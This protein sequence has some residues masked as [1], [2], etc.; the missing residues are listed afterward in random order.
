[1][2]WGLMMRWSCALTNWENFRHIEATTRNRLVQDWVQ[3]LLNL[4]EK[5]PEIEVLS[6]GEVQPGAVGD[7]NT[8]V[9]A[10]LLFE[11]KPLAKE[12]LRKIYYWLYEDMTARLP[13]DIGLG[14]TE[15]A[16][17]KR[18]FLVGQPVDLGNFG[19]LR[20]ALGI[21]NICFME[22]HGVERALADDAALVRKISLLAR[23]HDRIESYADIMGPD[24]RREAS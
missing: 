1:M 15:Q 9:S 19:V 2:N 5:H 7:R 21:H 16:I 22:Q 4:I 13:E 6:G 3:G 24:I 23:Y 11:G 20:I 8:I 14:K 17:L 10:K 18:P 12:I